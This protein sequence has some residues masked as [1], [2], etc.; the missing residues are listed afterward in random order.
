M[1]DAT[2]QGRSERG[3]DV[4]E[5]A[6][7]WHE[8]LQRWL[9]DAS[10]ADACEPTAMVLATADA[11]GAPSART[12]LL[13]ELSAQGLVFYTNLASRKGQDMAA[14]PRAAVVFPWF[15][16]G[17]QAIAAGVV[18]LVRAE[19]ADA[20]FASR[21]YGSQ[22]SAHASRQSQVIA[23]RAL[24]E[25]AHAELAARYP[26]SAAVPRPADWSGFRLAPATVEFWQGRADRL[27]DR[28]RYRLDADG[29]WLI[30]RLSP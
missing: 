1:S 23:D 4:R 14:N 18:E 22:I 25:A 29:D 3:L 24:L 19:D 20:Y 27:H 2:R 7:T 28:L 21:P 10:A 30:E 8:Q 9:S 17:R 12:V 16:I 15:A 11:T 13:K 6:P 26:R 5:L